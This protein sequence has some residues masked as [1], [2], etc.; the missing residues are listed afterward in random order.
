[1]QTASAIV[2]TATAPL[3]PEQVIQ[4]IRESLLVREGLTI[5]KTIAEERARNIATV[6]CAMGVAV[7]P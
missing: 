1:M 4:I 5:T 6:L 2:D 3:T 7:S